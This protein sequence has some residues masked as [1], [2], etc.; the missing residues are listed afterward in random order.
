MPSLRWRPDRS[1]VAAARWIWRGDLGKS[2]GGGRS[3]E[4][5]SGD[6]EERER[7]EMKK[8]VHGRVNQDE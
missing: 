6:R 1:S 8:G 4:I 5:S 3:R 2:R 7:G